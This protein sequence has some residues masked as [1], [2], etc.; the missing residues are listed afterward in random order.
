MLAEEK[1][2]RQEDEARLAPEAAAEPMA[3]TFEVAEKA[4][5]TPASP[6]EPDAAAAE[7]ARQSY[8]HQ[9]FPVRSLVEARENAQ[10]FYGEAVELFEMPAEEISA[11]DAE[12]IHGNLI[13]FP[14]ELVATRKIRPRLA[15]GPYGSSRSAQLSIF[16]VDP[17]AVST[18]AEAAESNAV[19]WNRAEWSGIELGA[20]PAVEAMEPVAAAA[21][22]EI[23]LAPLSRRLLAAVVDAALISAAVLA[24]AALFAANATALPGPREMGMGAAAAF[25]AVTALYELMFFMMAPT[26]PGMRYAH[27][28]LCTFGNEH[29]T[30]QQRW[31]RLAAMGLSVLPAG[32]GL[33]WSL[34]DEERLCWHDRLSQTYL[35]SSF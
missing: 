31:R 1:Q 16:E 13:E 2:S 27:I 33:V 7:I 9:L 25:V 10:C 19:E 17:G 29:P 8:S 3:M 5:T 20:E 32:L 28:G 26:T 23:D 6:A 14:R 30:R 24:A 21:Y 22:A 12:P 35:R 34:F 11:E 15:E 18:E 4:L